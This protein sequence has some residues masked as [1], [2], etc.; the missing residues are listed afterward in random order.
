MDYRLSEL[1]KGQCGTIIKNSSKGIIRR[2]LLDMGIVKGVDFK[3]L[4]K[5][6][7]GDPLELQINGFFLS[8][9]K[10]EAEN[11]FVSLKES[12]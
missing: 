10:K 7:F 4:R 1:N 6:P 3:V 9:R 8:L 2:R 5:A 12:K 11:I